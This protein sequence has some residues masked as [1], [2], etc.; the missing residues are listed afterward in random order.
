MEFDIKVIST[1]EMIGEKPIE[2]EKPKRGK[3]L[4]ALVPG[5]GFD[6]DL[7]AKYDG[8][9]DDGILLTIKADGT[10]VLAADVGMAL[11]GYPV[12]KSGYV[13]VDRE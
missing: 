5:F 6:V 8:T 4:L 12:T 2:R 10:I 3:L 9:D 1:E 7:I 13:K 11:P